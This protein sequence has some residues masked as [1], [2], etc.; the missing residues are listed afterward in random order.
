MVSTIA[1]YQVGYILGRRA[2]PHIF[3]RKDSV[4]FKAEYMAVTEKFFARHG[5]KTILI[6]RFIAVIRTIVPL[7]AGIGKMD[8]KRFFIFNV[9]GGV[10]WSAGLILLSYYVGTKVPHLDSYIK[11]L[12]LIAIVLTW[13]VAA[14][15]LFKKPG[16]RREIL[17][18]L[19]DEYRS[20]FKK[21]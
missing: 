11:D 2:G 18:A 20:L 8:Q 13:A 21:R 1:G 16:R 6:A 19:R 17:R 12:V 10:L 14:Y 4:L 7:V 3:N 15:E 5:W 9:I